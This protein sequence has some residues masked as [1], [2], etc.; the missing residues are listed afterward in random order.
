M[1]EA[2][3]RALLVLAGLGAVLALIDPL[4]PFGALLG[5][6]ALALVTLLTAAERRRAGK[7]EA[8]WW[9]LLAAG[10][11]MVAL[12]VPLALLVEVVG[13]LLTAVGGAAAVT[14]V[15]LG[16]PASPDRPA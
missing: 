7:A 10:T 14:A 11:A 13:G 2:R 12:G 1:K 15:A 9:R 3:L 4:E 8:N 5:L 6:S 16:L